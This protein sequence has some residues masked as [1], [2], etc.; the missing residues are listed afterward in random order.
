MVAASG[1]PVETSSIEKK[2]KK[3]I[4][5]CRQHSTAETHLK[6][7]KALFVFSKHPQ[8]HVISQQICCPETKD[9][10]RGRSCSPGFSNGRIA[11]L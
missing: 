6:K 4:G 5:V 1:W 2:K 7:C 10:R 9:R 8:L 3:K 11:K